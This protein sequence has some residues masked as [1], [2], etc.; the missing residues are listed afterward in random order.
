MKK[1]KKFQSTRELMGVRALTDYGMVTD[2]G[3]LVFFVIKPTNIGVLPESSITERVRALMNVLRSLGEVEMLAL[4]S[5]ASFQHNKSFYRERMEQEPLAPVRE[6][7]D[8][9]CAHL[10]E[11]QSR[12]STAR[13]FYLVTRLRGEPDGDLSQHLADVEQQINDYGFKVR[14]AGREDLKRILSVYYEQN[15]TSEVLQDYDGSQWLGPPPAKKP[16]KQKKKKGKRAK[17]KEAR[18]DFL[19]MVAPSVIRFFSEYYVCGSTYRCVWALREYPVQTEEQALLRHLG[20]KNGVSLHIYASRLS[21]TDEERTFHNAENKNRMHTYNPNNLRQA[22]L[23]ASNLADIS[24]ISTAMRKNGEP[25]VRCAAFLELSAENEAE[26]KKLQSDVLAGLVR[27]KLNV[28]KL[29]LR[30]QQGFHCVKPGGTNIFGSQF[31]RVLPASSVANLYP[32]NYSGRTDPR[33]FYIGKDRFGTNILV[34]F[35]QLDPDKTS[36]NIL[37][38]GNS[39]QG[40]SYLMKLLMTNI[41]ESGKS[42][43]SLDAEHE[44]R[45]MC[46]SLGGYF[47]DLMTGEYR[48]NVLEPKCWANSDDPLEQLD[49]AAPETFRKSSVLAQHISFLKDFFRAYKD[50]SDAHIDTIEILLARLYAEWDITEQ[51]DFNRLSPEQVPILSDLYAL[52]YREYEAYDRQPSQLYTKRLL[53]EVLLGLH[54]MCVG[55]D[56]PFFNGRTNI[57]SSRFLVFGV[58]GLTNAAKNVRAAIL[59]NILSY[60]SNKLLAEGNTVA[61]LDELYIWLDNPVAIEYIRNSLKRVRKRRSALMMASQNLEDFD[62]PNVREMTR[63]LFSIPPHQFLFNAGTIS[64]HSYMDML[65]L[66]DAEYELIRYPRQGLCLYKC[67]NERYLLEVTA[68]AYKAALFGKAGG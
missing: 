61:T 31:E 18:K 15:V 13:E 4:N 9:D 33:G 54:S 28:D 12:L 19:D 53:Q 35:D 6:L 52:I 48:I 32:F 25:L 47:I 63:P 55:S 64:K 1:N 24:S 45:E 68:P 37:I 59:F 17:P 23:A 36:G 66:E 39:G 16:E 56:A 62:Q 20:E 27:S 57:S 67:G 42:V 46:E 44:Q 38:L 10:D 41:L 26:L 30:Q 8:R 43:I 2:N 11:M 14:R 21:L 3:T 40:K 58:G 34:D 51:T 22:A 5:W 50:F 65:Q 29:L 49:R 60:M 7:L